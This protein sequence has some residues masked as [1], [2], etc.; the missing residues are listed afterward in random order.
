MS[1]H[2]RVVRGLYKRI[3][4]LHEGFPLDLKVIGDQYVKSEFKLHKDSPP[5]FIPE[6]LQQWNEYADSLNSQIKHSGTHT[7][8]LG[9]N[10]DTKTLD[11]LSDDQAV[12]LFELMKETNKE[13]RQFNIKEED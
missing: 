11:N 13:N 2:S 6:F 12:Q 10:L 8:S 1:A 5:E 7:Q 9:K 3:L 4:R